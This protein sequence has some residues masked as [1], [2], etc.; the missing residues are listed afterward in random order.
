M[1]GQLSHVCR[2]HSCMHARQRSAHGTCMCDPAALI[3][4]QPCISGSVAYPYIMAM[5]PNASQ[6]PEAS[7]S[8]NEGTFEEPATVKT[9]DAGTPLR[10]VTELPAPPPTRGYMVFVPHSHMNTAM[11]WDTLLG[12][13]GPPRLPGKPY[14]VIVRD[15]ETQ[16][17]E[18]CLEEAGRNW[19]E[20]KYWDGW[21]RGYRVGYRDGYSNWYGDRQEMAD[22][23]QD[24]CPQGMVR[25][26]DGQVIN[27]P[28]PP[29]RPRTDD[30]RDDN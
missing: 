14:P 17:D 27:Q 10:V 11:P 24:D 22:E 7:R 23:S 13:M 8:A 1:Q 15:Q 2:I 18:S 25:T 9:Q 20:Q 21:A 19:S 30:G 12:A 3:S 16:T 4:K 26:L 29:K 6:G 28:P 5:D